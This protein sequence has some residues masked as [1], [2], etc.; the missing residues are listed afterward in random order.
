M[1]QIK[2]PLAPNSSLPAQN[3]PSGRV[4]FLDN[5]KTFIILL[6]VF[7]HSAYAY[8]IYYSVDWYVIDTQKSLFFDVFITVA[9]AFMMPT[10]FFVAGYFGNRS[11]AS[12]GLLPFWKDKLYR[13]IIPWALGVLILAP[14]R[15]YMHSLSRHLYPSYLCYWGHYF[16]GKEYQTHGQA[17]FYFLGMLT[18]FYAVLSV[19]YIIRRRIGNISNKPTKPSSLFFVIFGLA[20]GLIF[21]GGNLVIGE[22][23]W[24]K[25]AIFDVPGSRFI[26]YMAYFF[27][28]VFAYKRQWFTPSGYNPALKRWLPICLPMC[29]LSFFLFLI[30]LDKK[31]MPGEIGMACYSL[32]YFFFCMTAV[33]SLLAFFQKRIDF[34]S[35]LLASLSANSY[36]I[37]FIHYSVILWIILALRELQWNP[38]VKWLSVGILSVIVCYVVARYAL[39][40]TPMF[41]SKVRPAQGIQYA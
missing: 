9:F 36:A 31:L 10:M 6:V 38:F 21:F 14:A 7:F 13:I 29:P 18:L 37:F 3:S 16:F 20:T 35:G 11:L 32:S 28:G 34:T 19:V 27:L 23:I 30:F 39:S 5:L 17:Q 12:K 4:Y 26:P 15:A 40:K 2:S 1:Q 8:S 25:I 24:P 33:F 22:A 41:S